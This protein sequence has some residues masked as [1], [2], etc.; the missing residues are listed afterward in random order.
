[1]R[2]V[3]FGAGSL[4]SALG[5]LLAGE[6]EVVLVG[7]RENMAA[8]RRS[9]LRVVGDLRRTVRLRAVEN[10]RSADDADLLII[11]T[12]AYDTGAAIDSCRHWTGKGTM[13]LTLQNGLGNL[14]LVRAWKGG[15]GFGGTTTM[16]ARLLSPGVVRLSGIGR[17]VI[18]SDFD[19][20]G[21]GRI[22]DALTAGE[23]PASTT[24]NINGE[25]WA[26]AAVNA[27]I[28]PVSAVL[29]VPNGRLLDGLPVKRLVRE[30]SMECEAVAAEAGIALPRRPVFSMVVDVARGTAGNRS[31]MLQDV[32][33]RRRTEIDQ[34]NGEICRVGSAC[35]VA[36]PLNRTLTAMV[37]AL[38][39]SWTTEKG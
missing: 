25:L 9:G 5:G 16:G 24:S 30:V 4:G 34:I 11:T 13:V 27:C 15:L 31:S 7:R 20:P 17:T 6:H 14:E 28:N 35:G 38:E 32:E 36:T 18:G 33:R 21:A 39:A 26:K 3:V 2:I 22:A 23:I 10:V 8:I 37:K 1:M 12:K 29:R 19:P